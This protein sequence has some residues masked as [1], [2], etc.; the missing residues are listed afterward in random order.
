MPD[1]AAAEREVRAVLQ[2]YFDGLYRSDVDLLRR[3]LHPR[4]VYVCATDEDLVH[5]TRD[6][7][8]PVVAARPSPESRG[9]P[10]RDAIDEVRFAGPST[11]F[12][13]VRCSI[14]DRDFTDFLTLIHDAGRWSI[15]SKVFHYELRASEEEST[16]R[17]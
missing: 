1:P 17:T 6:E 15:V 5:K 13:R 16:C 3:A 12:A 4:A 7:Y 8:L 2:V 10:R 11:A 14:G 9:E